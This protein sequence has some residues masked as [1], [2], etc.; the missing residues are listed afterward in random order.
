[1][2]RRLRG[3]QPRTT[4]PPSHFL[5]QP[6]SVRTFTAQ[7]CCLAGDEKFTRCLTTIVTC[8]LTPPHL[9]HPGL[10]HLW[11]AAPGTRCRVVS[12]SCNVASCMRPSSTVSLVQT[13]DAGQTPPNKEEGFQE[14]QDEAEEAVQGAGHAGQEGGRGAV[15]PGAPLHGV[16]EAHGIPSQEHHDADPVFSAQDTQQR[17]VAVRS[18]LAATRRKTCSVSADS[19]PVAQ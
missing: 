18:V 1:M 12:E 17:C 11:S 8:V 5:H 14:G 2:S 7:R 3:P 13:P 9:Q 10:A 4:P 19:I 6:P 15:R 16:H